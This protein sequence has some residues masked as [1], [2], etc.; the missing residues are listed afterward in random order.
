[1]RRTSRRGS[2]SGAGTAG[3]RSARRAS[4]RTARSIS[5]ISPR[6]STERPVS[7]RAPAPRTGSGRSFL[8]RRGCGS[9][10]RTAGRA[11]PPAGGP[12]GARRALKWALCGIREHE[13]T[14]SAEILRGFHDLRTRGVRLHGIDDPA[15]LDERDPTFLF[16]VRGLT[17]NEIKRRLWEDARIEVPSGTCYSLAVYRA[18]KARRAVRASFAHYDD[19]GTVRTFLAALG[20]IAGAAPGSRS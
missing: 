6:S 18:L 9:P 13:K 1:M 7:S 11:P 12:A 19:L 3:S 20:R 17:Q 15:R 4:V 5:I 16:E 8:W 10:A 14:L 2:R